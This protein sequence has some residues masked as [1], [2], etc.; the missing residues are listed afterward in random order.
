MLLSP[1]EPKIAYE[2][3]LG[4][5]YQHEVLEEVRRLDEA[6]LGQAAADALDTGST[7]SGSASRTPTSGG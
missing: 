4:A 6:L 7:S 5:M 1:N 3:D 2:I